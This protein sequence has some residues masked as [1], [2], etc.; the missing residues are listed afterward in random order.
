MTFKELKQGYPI[1][2]LDK[3]K[4]TVKQGKVQSVAFPRVDTMQGQRQMVVDITVEHN[5]TTATYT[6]PEDA[7]LVY[8]NNLVISTEPQGLIVEV[9]KMK[10]E[11]EHILASVE[12][13]KEI[14]EVA[15][16]LLAKLNPAFKEKR[17]TEQRFEQMEKRMDKVDDNISQLLSLVKS[18]IQSL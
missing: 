11:A 16:E 8:A 6:M 5:G 17:E 18:K 9:E 10:S 13:Q 14:V 1:H 3:D 12:H 7:C 2:I 15:D 4:L